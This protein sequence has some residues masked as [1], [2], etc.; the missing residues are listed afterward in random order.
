TRLMLFL[1]QA[2]LWLTFAREAIMITLLDKSIKASKRI[3]IKAYKR[4]S[5]MC[6]T[7]RLIYVST[8]AEVKERNNMIV[9]TKNNVPEES[10]QQIVQFIERRDGM[11]GHISKG[12]DRTVIGIIGQADPQ[13][14]E[15]LKSM[16][17]VE[18][19]IKISK[20]YKLASRDFHPND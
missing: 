3:S 6:Y 20:S 9:I 7:H 12:T 1:L 14:G 10:L 2:F 18:N 8:V 17:G 11:K 13:L 4:E 15:Q 5:V 19:V 16:R